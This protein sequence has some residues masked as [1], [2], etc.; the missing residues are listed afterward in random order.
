MLL[1]IAAGGLAALAASGLA[2]QKPSS[3]AG[4]AGKGRAFQLRVERNVVLVRVVVLDSHG[5]A[6]PGLTRK[7]FLLFDNGKRQTI[8]GFM[9]RGGSAPAPAPATAAPAAPA[10]S[11]APAARVASATPAAPAAIPNQFV[12]LY[13]DDL[14]M[15]F[16]NVVFTRNAAERYLKTELKPAARVGLFT[17]SG[18]DQVDFTANRQKLEQAL[19]KLQPRSMEGPA[20][21]ACPPLTD[22]EAYLINHEDVPIGQS[23]IAG[24]GRGGSN[25]FVVASS[26]PETPSA[27]ALATEEVIQCEC[28]GDVS[29][30][31]NPAGRAKAAARLR[32]D[33]AEHQVRVSLEGLNRLVERMAQM[34][35]RRTI[36]YIS[37]GFVD[38]T[39]LSDLSDIID[40][41]VREG[42]V[43]NGLD[44]SG[45][46]AEAPGGNA[47][48]NSRVLPIAFEA[49]RVQIQRNGDQQQSD[50]LA[51]LANGTGGIFFHNNN[52]YDQG[53]REAGGLP[54]LAYVLEFSPSNLKNNGAYHHLKVKLASTAKRHGFRIEA[55]KGY[56]A[57]RK[58]AS[59]A[60]Q[61]KQQIHH[62]VF[63]RNESQGLPLKV[64]TSFKKAGGGK[65]DLT[66]TLHLGADEL[67]FTKEG[68][69]YE[70]RFTS[71]TAIF[72]HNG[73][74]L[75][76]TE[77][78]ADLHL[79][80]RDLKRIRKKGL[81]LNL[82]FALA[83]GDY[84]VRDVVRDSNGALAAVNNAV[85]IKF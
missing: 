14:W 34:P 15:P 48:D 78:N 59:S 53:F 81:K 54:K 52:D 35:G 73:R 21:S 9:T 26:L 50:V 83:P 1:L 84:L 6:V 62:A 17:S 13:Y 31:R 82:Q 36:L 24:P 11:A 7:D 51:E 77:R 74:Y 22:Y 68:D 42:V 19:V 3:A 55:R 27:L 20:G 70:D 30:C 76:Q 38:M 72:D 25:E 56:Y 58:A 49:M 8:S 5:K 41:A 69:R 64:K 44:S 80:E 79:T 67:N 37:P 28:G 71:V 39:L 16:S 47:S 43:I 29:H 46:R 2:A 75:G 32:W 66:V 57:P 40:R 61:A 23:P 33:Q 10:A 60:A 85:R 4:K 18:R 63:S 12:A 65:A 45:L